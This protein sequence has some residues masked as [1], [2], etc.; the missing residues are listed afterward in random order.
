M[1]TTVVVKLYVH[2]RRWIYSCTAVLCIQL[3]GSLVPTGQLSKYYVQF[4]IMQLAAHLLVVHHERQ[5]TYSSAKFH[6]INVLPVVVHLISS[7]PHHAASCSRARFSLHNFVPPYIIRCSAYITFSVNLRKNSCRLSVRQSCVH[8]GMFYFFF[9]F[10]RL[11]SREAEKQGSWEN[12]EAEKQRSREVDPLL[13]LSRSQCMDQV[14]A[15]HA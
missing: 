2:T 5:R 6:I 4:R 8:M 7:V 1:Y 12:R 14:C 15:H 9:G 13:N 11:R 10:S 3:Q